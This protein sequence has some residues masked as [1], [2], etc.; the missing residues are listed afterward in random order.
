MSKN[1]NKN[2]EKLLQVLEKVTVRIA[3]CDEQAALKTRGA[4]F[5]YKSPTM[6]IPILIT[7]GHILVGAK[8]FIETNIVKD[9]K[10]LLLAGGKFTVHYSETE[11]YG[12]SKLPVKLYRTQ[13]EEL[14]GVE[15]N[16]YKE[17]F[18]KA[19]EN[20]AYSFAVVNN[21][22]EFIINN[23]GFLLCPYHC[24]EVFMELED[25]NENFNYFK[26]SREFG[27][28]EY[29]S[30]ASGSPIADPSGRITSILVSGD[31]KTKILKSFRLDNINLEI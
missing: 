1:S 7:A 30:G 29:Y 31:E 21:Y 27:G 25:Q 5:L 19:V 17:K 16:F 13:Y 12:Y 4:G 26:L 28:H 14:I 2:I 20:E 3:V 11:D 6:K 23:G 8:C 18:V 9:D 15:L 22:P 24:Y 10:M